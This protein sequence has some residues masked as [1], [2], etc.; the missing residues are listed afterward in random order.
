MGVGKHPDFDCHNLEHQIGAFTDCIHGEGLAVIT[1]P[2]YR[3]LMPYAIDRF[4][5]FAVNV[6]KLSPQGSDEL[7]AKAGIDALADFI[8]RAGLPTTMRQLGIKDE[9]EL[10]KIAATVQTGPGSYH[11]CSPEDVEKI[12]KSCW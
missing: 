7:L 3:W 1:P 8:A 12:F 4:V 6:W 5:R 2:Y 10:K 11:K 9:A